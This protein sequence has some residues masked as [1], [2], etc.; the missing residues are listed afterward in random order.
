M[1]YVVK[2]GSREIRVDD[3]TEAATMGGTIRE[4]TPKER[5]TPNGGDLPSPISQREHPYAN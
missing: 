3:L 1:S 5:A 4:A 2:V